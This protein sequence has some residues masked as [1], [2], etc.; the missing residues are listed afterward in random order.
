MWL[1]L[2]QKLGGKNWGL[3]KLGIIAILGFFL[4]SLLVNVAIK[5]PLNANKPVDGLLVLGGSIRREI[6]VAKLAKEYP[7]IPILI[8]TGS[9]D[10]CI[11][12][13]FQREKAS[14]GYVWLERCARSTF[15]NYF[16]STP[17]LRSWGVHKVKVLT[18]SSHLPR[19]KLLGQIMLGAKGIWAE[20]EI[21]KEKGVPG[22]RES[23]LK[24]SLDLTRGLLWGFVSQAIQ[25]S[26]SEITHLSEVELEEWIEKGFSCEHQ[27]KVKIPEQIKKP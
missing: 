14:I 10:P 8:S 9:D 5:L 15:G 12:L 4:L 1:N 7:E 16:F 26:C 21:V 6:H 11:L 20:I 18:S 22:N 25:P 13:I 27:G 19:A 24:T 3:V 2:R 23:K 17:I